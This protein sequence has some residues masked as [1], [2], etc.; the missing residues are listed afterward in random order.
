MPQGMVIK[1]ELGRV[2]LDVTT[3]CCRFL[4]GF[5]IAGRGEGGH[6]TIGGANQGK[7][8]AFLT[9]PVIPDLQN[10]VDPII[11]LSDTSLSWTWPTTNESIRRT[12][13]VIF[14]VY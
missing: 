14:G 6:L 5:A 4:G 3:R 11:T 1:D 13:N 12:Y 10:S 9:N 8:F 2:I 7:L